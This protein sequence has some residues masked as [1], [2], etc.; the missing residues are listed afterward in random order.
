MDW[1]VARI[2]FAPIKGT[3]HLSLSEVRLDQSGPVGDRRFCLV[4]P[5]ASRALRTVENPDLVTVSV[6]WRDP[7]LCC[8]FPDGDEVGD[9]VRTRDPA[10][11]FDYWG[12]QVTGR[13]VDG[14]WGEAFS[15]RIGRRLVLV[16]CAPGAVVFGDSVTVITTSSLDALGRALATP[17]DAARLRATLVIDDHGEEAPAVA[18]RESGWPGRRLVVGAAEVEITA[19][20]ARC[21][22]IDIHPVTGNRDGRL[23]RTLATIAARD[24]TFGDPVF[25]VQGRVVRPGVV[26]PGDHARLLDRTSTA[27]SRPR[28]APLSS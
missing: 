10:I 21:A 24:E 12:R 27:E 6:D 9:A 13:V 16:A 5:A 22:V 20:V 28:R 3:R 18:A 14:P 26:R 19:A 15:R 23:L 4:D 11:T 2:G 25:G 17:V 7:F 8:A 1:Q